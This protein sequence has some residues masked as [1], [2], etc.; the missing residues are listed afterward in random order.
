MDRQPENMMPAIA[1]RDDTEMKKKKKKKHNIFAEAILTFCLTGFQN[2]VEERTFIVA[3]M[4]S[5]V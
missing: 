4:Q 1:R 2:N 3:K 5:L